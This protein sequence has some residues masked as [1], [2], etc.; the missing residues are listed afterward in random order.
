MKRYLLNVTFFA[1]SDEPQ[2]TDRG[3]Y[4]LCVDR[5]ITEEKMQNIFTTV[6]RLLDVFAESDFPISY[7]DGLNIYTLMDGVEIYTQGRVLAVDSNY[8]A[9]EEID[10][11]YVIEQWQ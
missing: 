11:Y 2:D 7:N 1:G 5:E 6:N 8:G 10:N 3:M 9:F 4:I